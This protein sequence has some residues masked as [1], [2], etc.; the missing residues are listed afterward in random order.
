MNP[1]DIR[2]MIKKLRWIQLEMMG[3]RI[4]LQSAYDVLEE[5]RVQMDSICDEL[6][7]ALEEKQKQR[8]KE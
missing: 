1:I 5:S 3:S 7:N 8:G 6:I 4:E 2:H